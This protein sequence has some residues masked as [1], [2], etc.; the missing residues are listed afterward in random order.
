MADSFWT[1]HKRRIAVLAWGTL[2]VLLGAAL[3]GERSLLRLQQLQDEQHRIEA[4][5]EARKRA[6]RELRR[7]LDA[8][9]HDP[10]YQERLAREELGLVRPGEIVY[11]FPD[12]PAP[13]RSPGGADSA[14]PAPHAGAP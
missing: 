14:P 11:R 2:A 3:F 4:S 9:R 13:S 1:R 8:L 7:E 6:N 12:T 5:I 10:A